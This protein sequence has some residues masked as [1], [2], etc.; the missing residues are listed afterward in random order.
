[1]YHAVRTLADKLQPYKK[2]N[3]GDYCKGTE[4][5]WFPP[6]GCEADVNFPYTWLKGKTGKWD[7]VCHVDNVDI[8][9]TLPGAVAS[10]NTIRGMWRLVASSTHGASV[11]VETGFTSSTSNTTTKTEKKS[12]SQTISKSV[13]TMNRQGSA[14]NGV[15][16]TTEQAYS[17]TDTRSKALVHSS[18]SALQQSKSTMITV[19]C[20]DQELLRHST[21]GLEPY[22]KTT[23]STQPSQSMEYVYQWVVGNAEY[24]VKT[25]NFRCHRV[26]DGVKK[27]PQ[28]PPQLC[29]N[30]F[31]NPYCF[32]GS[33]GQKGADPN[34]ARWI[35]EQ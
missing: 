31:E 20:P 28:C 23:W 16:Y 19:S 2:V 29:G 14:A 18:E 1:V 24:E 33:N 7:K 3:S 12:F 35:G 25:Q 17:L 27:D 26:A 11:S 34:C 22:N 5:N 21:S 8:M 15:T 13:S 10:D 4:Q 6:T 30:P 32:T 9:K